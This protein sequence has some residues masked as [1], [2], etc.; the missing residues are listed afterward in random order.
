M[1]QEKKNIILKIIGCGLIFS[2]IIINPW[3]LTQVLS[4]DEEIANLNK[5]LIGVTSI[6]FIIFGLLTV[7]LSSKKYIPNYY[8]IMFSIF[9]VSP[10]AG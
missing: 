1:S 10:I 2:G 5:F 4:V 9:F 3:T 7:V 6:G 8:L